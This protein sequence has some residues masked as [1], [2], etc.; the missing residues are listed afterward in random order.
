MF[1]FNFCLVDDPKFSRDIHVYYA[2]HQLS[3]DLN[4]DMVYFDIVYFYMMYFD[5]VSLS[6]LNLVCATSR[7]LSTMQVCEAKV[8]DDLLY[9]DK[10][11]GTL[12]WD[13]H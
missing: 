12:D 3:S 13:I 8:P 10:E 4:F 6:L 1:G 2:A 11:V 7:F 9:K 5:I